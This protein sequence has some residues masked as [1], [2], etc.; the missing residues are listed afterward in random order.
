MRQSGTSSKIT[1]LNSVIASV[2][3]AVYIGA[4]AMAAVRIFINFTEYRLFAHGEFLS[5]SDRAVTATP[6]GFM[7]QSYQQTLQEN[8][9]GTSSLEG[10]IISGFQEG[11]YVSF[12]FE[13]VRG[14]SVDWQDGHRFKKGFN[15]SAEVFEQPLRI[16]GQGSLTISGIYNPV[17]YSFFV[18]TLKFTLIL[19]GAAL[20]LS[21][22]TLIFGIFAGRKQNVS[23]KTA[24]LKTGAAARGER[25]AARGEP[26]AAQPQDPYSARSHIL[27]EALAVG[28]LASELRRAAAAD[29][30]LSL[31]CLE[32]KDPALADEAL[33]RQFA[34]EAARFFSRRD[35]CFEKGDWGI[36]VIANDM[37]LDEALLKAGEFQGR[38]ASLLT[39]SL[40]E[41]VGLSAGIS[42]RAE[43]PVD[44]ERLLFEAG[45]ALQKAM[46]EDGQAMIAFRPDPEKYQAFMAQNKG[47]P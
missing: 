28:R 30:E 19:I 41:G 15:L 20:G 43:R 16:P 27:R 46:Q 8:L 2:C 23:G 37:T 24:V 3:I 45:A 7:S 13:R 12:A 32:L 9:L 34:G 1:V 44:A 26:I 38:F 40:A 39:G 42:S 18:D 36:T 5:F 25:I 21:F 35:L 31:I 4:I 33:Y 22:L 47:R 14:S 6:L 10:I 11:N 17:N 29:K